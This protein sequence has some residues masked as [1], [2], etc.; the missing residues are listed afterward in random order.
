MKKLVGYCC[1]KQLASRTS[2][3]PMR[4]AIAYCCHVGSSHIET[5]YDADAGQ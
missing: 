2:K 5:S 4:I 3:L 1:F